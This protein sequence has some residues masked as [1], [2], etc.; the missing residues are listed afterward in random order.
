M[1]DDNYKDPNY[2]KNYYQ[3]NKGRLDKAK[4]EYRLK[5]KDKAKEYV[6]RSQLKAFYGITP[7]QYDSMLESQGN[8]CAIC[9]DD[10]KSRKHTHVDHNHTTNTVRQ[11]LC[12]SCNR[13]LGLFKENPKILTSA[14]DYL[15]KWNI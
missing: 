12:S 15:N 11:L 7:E 8:K 4:A 14:L 9:H 5:N 6:R 1:S 13:A 2:H 3:A 10:F